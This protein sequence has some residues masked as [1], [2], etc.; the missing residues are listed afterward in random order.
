MSTPSPA[1]KSTAQRLIEEAA[2]GDDEEVALVGATEHVFQGLHDHLAKLIG[3]VG[4]RTLL[5][6]ALQLARADAPALAVVEVKPNGL[7][8][9]LSRAL[10]GLR[11]AEALAAPVTLLAHFLA[12]LSA[13]VGEDLTVHVVSEAVKKRDG[14]RAAHN[15]EDQE[16]AHKPGSEDR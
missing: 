2:R 9:G 11:P 6:R 15:R 10:V 3:V 16:S 12:L 7:I 13:F 8:A 4:F 1:H 5:A 14:T